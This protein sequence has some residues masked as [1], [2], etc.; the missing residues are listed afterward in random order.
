MIYLITKD[1]FSN[2]FDRLLSTLVF[3]ILPGFISAGLLLNNS[4]I[5]IFCLLLYLYYYKIL[6]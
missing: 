6:Y 4:I 5:V 2:E 3:M 1:Y